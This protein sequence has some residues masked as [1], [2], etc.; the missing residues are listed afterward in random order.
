MAKVLVI[1]NGGREHALAWALSRS[2]Q[3]EQVYVAP[4]NGGT[5]WDAADGTGLK[6]CAPSQNVEIA[7]DDFD[8]LI[9]FARENHVDL[10][11]VGPEVPLVDGIVDAFQAAGLVIF[12][13]VQGAAQLE[14]SKAFAKDFMTEQ[15]IPTGE[16]FTT[17]DY[18][19]A[20]HFL[21][22][23][24]QPV[25]VK[26][27]GLAAGKGVL[28]CDT[29][30]EAETALYQVMVDKA[31]GDAGSTVVIEE[32]LSGRELSVLAFCDGKTVKPMI[33]ARDYK[34]A[35]DGNKG[36]NT[37]GMGAIAPADDVSQELIDSITETAL[38]PVIEGMKN[39]GIPYVGVLYAGIM[40]T[41]SGAKVLE[42]NCRFGDPE[43]QVILPLLKTDL[44]AIMLACIN[45]TLADI[46]IEWH[47][48][49]C[50]T[51]VCAAPGYP[52]S[53]P[54]ELPITGIDTFAHGIV[55]HAGTTT[56]D[57]QLVTNGGRV[58]A[59][60]ALGDTLEAALEKS[61]A[62]VDSILF[63]NMH[64]RTDIGKIYD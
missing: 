60:T 2:P 27:S 52:E 11:V 36:L 54:K 34:R 9:K 13:S 28:I 61:Y 3:V 50:S 51:V 57:S 43:T 45:G 15:N 17:D 14:G 49:Y 12:G 64:F 62:G 47:D 24:K 31:F 46:E 18:D 59:V 23:Y 40:L 42:Y 63:D 55:F 1:G 29:R 32:R 6:P 8:A 39:L 19:E 10:T 30:E 7:V 16:Y 53:Y 38:L 21:A 4:G 20:R 5:T 22:E 26:A 35:L 56:K 58:L 25:V 48:A 41:E 33:V 37:G 44:Y